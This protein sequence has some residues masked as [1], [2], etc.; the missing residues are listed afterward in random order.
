VCKFLASKYI[1][2]ADPSLDVSRALWDDS[3]RKFQGLTP[4]ALFR[5]RSQD[6]DSLFL[7]PLHPRPIGLPPTAKIGQQFVPR[8]HG[9][10]VSYAISTI[11]KWTSVE[12]FPCYVVDQVASSSG[13]SLPLLPA[14]LAHIGIVDEFVDP[15]AESGGR[16]RRCES[17]S[18]TIPRGANLVSR[19]Q[20]LYLEVQTISIQ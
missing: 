7:G 12:P 2:N 16:S 11:E 9:H 6:E 1:F 14:M 18:D 19:G 5:R 3:E 8:S 4:A 13:V 20:I 17:G 10:T 15:K